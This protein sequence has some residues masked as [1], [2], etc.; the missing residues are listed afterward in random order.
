MLKQF[1]VI[2]LLLQAYFACI[3]N[4]TE[5]PF[6]FLFLQTKWNNFDA[7]HKTLEFHK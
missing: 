3:Y 4:V 5:E 7:F 2:L 6:E 1:T